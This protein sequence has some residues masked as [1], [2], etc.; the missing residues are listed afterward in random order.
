MNK[1]EKGIEAMNFLFIQTLIT[2]KWEV[3][4]SILAIGQQLHSATN[5]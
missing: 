3:A 5:I 4:Y 2:K 1:N